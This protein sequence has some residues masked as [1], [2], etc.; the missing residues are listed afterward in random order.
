MNSGTIGLMGAM[1]LEVKLIAESITLKGT[2]QHVERTFYRG[3]FAGRDVVI[4]QSGVGKVRA[5]T[6]CQFLLEHFGVERLIF[7]GVAGG[8]RPGLSIGDI[9][10]SERAMEWD[11][12]SL[13]LPRCWYHADP[14]LVS[15]AVRS[16]E[17]LGRKVHI[18]SV[19]TGD[20]PIFKNEQKQDLW[21]TFNADCV[22][23][24]G[25]AV[26]QVCVLNAIPFVL[27]RAVS[28][29]A[30]EHSFVNLVRNLR[31]VVAWPA[32]VALEMVKSLV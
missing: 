4:V 9:I 2:E 31:E 23:M 22:E 20:R 11:F 16:A 17:R 26:A 13:M 6:A 3:Q 25:A 27:I 28:D 14:A 19:L 29:L 7:A 18:G 10:V 5:A 15:L 30:D 1:E 24:E 8:L 32:E 12:H 21:R